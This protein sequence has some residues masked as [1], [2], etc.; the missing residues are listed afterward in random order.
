[1]G[2]KWEPESAKLTLVSLVLLF[3]VV[4]SRTARLE[5]FCERVVLTL[6]PTE[7]TEMLVS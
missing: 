5:F 2:L 4:V 3:S 7:A 6:I 1:M